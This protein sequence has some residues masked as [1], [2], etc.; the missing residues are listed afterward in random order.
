MNIEYELY[1]PKEWA[2]KDE[3]TI[4]FKHIKSM[5]LPVTHEK[6]T[7]CP[8]CK[9]KAKALYFKACRK[10]SSYYIR[11]DTY[12][13]DVSAETL[14]HYKKRWRAWWR[15]MRQIKIKYGDIK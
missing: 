9:L 7:I 12:A 10:S 14:E 1:T 4:C 13:K 5:N 11:H 15:L 6:G 3:A 8:V 2:N